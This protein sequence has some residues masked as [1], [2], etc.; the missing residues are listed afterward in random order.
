MAVVNDNTSDTNVPGGPPAPN[1]LGG[2]LNIVV[3]VP[4]SIEIRMVDASTLAD[5][6]VWFFLSS[7]LSG[8]VIGFWVAA[9]QAL[10]AKAANSSQLVWT[11]I[12]FGILFV[13]TTITTFA[14]RHEL[15]KKGKNIQLRAVDA[16]PSSNN[17]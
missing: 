4:H 17:N 1:P 9:C 7:I 15:K 6:E 10:D 12:V 3:S 13:A 5:Y 14:K 2:S 8:A 11:A 16:S